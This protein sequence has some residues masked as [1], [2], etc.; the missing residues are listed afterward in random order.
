MIPAF[1]TKNIFLIKIKIKETDKITHTTAEKSKTMAL[2]SFLLFFLCLLSCEISLSLFYLIFKSFSVA[3]SLFLILICVK[4]F[5]REKRRDGGGGGG[6]RGRVG[7]RRRASLVVERIHRILWWDPFVWG[8][9]LWLA[10]SVWS[11]YC[12]TLSDFPLFC[13]FL[14]NSRPV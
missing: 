10:W 11:L 14:P 3:F 8:E 6:R 5:E 13:R 2:L 12:F 7:K 9:I 1:K 4:M